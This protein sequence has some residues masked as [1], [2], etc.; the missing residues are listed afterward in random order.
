MKGNQLIVLYCFAKR[1]L[2][3]SL[4]KLVAFQGID[5]QDML[6]FQVFEDA[7]DVFDVGTG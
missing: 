1:D 2:L 5:V 6:L 7:F 4:D 3:K